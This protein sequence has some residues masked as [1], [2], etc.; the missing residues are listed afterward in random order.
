L[1]YFHNKQWL[2]Y[3]SYRR[4][5]GIPY[6]MY[7]LPYIIYYTDAPPTLYV[8]MVTIRRICCISTKIKVS[9]QYFGRLTKEHKQITTYSTTPCHINIYF[10]IFFNQHTRNKVTYKL[11]VLK[12][13]LILQ[14]IFIYRNNNI[15]V[16]IYL[17]SFHVK[18]R[19]MNVKHLNNL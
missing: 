5:Y 7:T 4:L 1:R 18:V 19:E 12:I 8:K 16:L 6:I 9:W 17:N 11:Y 3:Y 15:W 10:N 14:S 13:I 2:P